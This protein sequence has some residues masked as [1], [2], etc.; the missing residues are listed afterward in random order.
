MQYMLR[1]KKAGIALACMM[2]CSSLAAAATG[3]TAAKCKPRNFGFD[4]SKAG[5]AHQPLSKLK[6]DTVYTLVQEDGRT[7]LR[8]AAD[9]SASAYVA[10]LKPAAVVPTI[11]V[12]AGR[13]TRWFRVPTTATR[14]AKTR[15]CV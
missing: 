12:G 14:T 11:L 13:R 10:R 4:Q 3:S 7:V 15:L 2:L 9:R 1:S 8:G 5:W 6:R